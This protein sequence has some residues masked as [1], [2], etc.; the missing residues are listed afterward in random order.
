MHFSPFIMT[1][2][3]VTHKIMSNFK[4]RHRYL[5]LQHK[6]L[7]LQRTLKEDKTVLC[8][9]EKKASSSRALRVANFMEIFNSCKWY[10]EQT[11][12]IQG[13]HCIKKTKTFFCFHLNLFGRGPIPSLEPGITW[14]SWSL[15]CH[16]NPQGILNFGTVFRNYKPSP[17]NNQNYEL[18]LKLR[19]LPT[20][21]LGHNSLLWVSPFRT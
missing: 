13:S 4:E 20:P 18:D 3:R 10:I 11:C 2:N 14:I 21:S 9:L 7:R 1:I 12:L 17:C 16:T 5:S 6:H 15:S 19:H 8:S